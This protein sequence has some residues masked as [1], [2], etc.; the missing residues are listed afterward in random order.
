MKLSLLTS[1]LAFSASVF[2]EEPVAEIE[3]EIVTDPNFVATPEKPFNFQIEYDIAFKEDETKDI[4][5]DLYNGET[6]ELLYTFKSL[7]PAEVSIV[8]VGGEL[9]DPVTGVVMANI[10]ASQIGPIS[11]LNN[12]IANFTQRVGIN[13]NPGKYLLVPAIYI[14]YQDQFMLLGSTNKLVN[15]V[16]PTVSFFDPQLILAELILGA[17]IAGIAYFIYNSYAST[18]LAGILPTSMLPDDKKKSSKLS[19]KEIKEQT[20]ATST[21]FKSWLPD[22]HK[23][24]S[25]KQK[26]KL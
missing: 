1:I 22:S 12:E 21:D 25:K 8:G 23:N 3:R 24:L 10:T 17:T 14:M 4:I 5:E 6:I 16:E 26:K 13:M 19:K 18:Y 15:V 9:L 2:A 20:S 7:E 11:V